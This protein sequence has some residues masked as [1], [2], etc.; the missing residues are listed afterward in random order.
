MRTLLLIIIAIVAY[1]CGG[2]NGAIISSRFIF[3]DDVRKHGSGN[4]GLTNFHRTY[5]TKGAAMVIAIDVLKSVIAVLVGGWLLG[6]VG[7]KSVGQIFAGFCLILGH[8]AP[9][10]YGFRGGKG[11]LC[12]GT[13]ILIVDPVAG[14][15]CWAV[16]ILVVIATRY[17]SLASMMACLLGPVFL[18]IFKHSGLEVLLT[19]LAAL[20]VVIKHAENIL[21]L[22]GGTESRLSF[23]KKE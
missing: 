3:H 18:A 13:M 10:L 23:G 12:A 7:E 9:V 22:I 19:L 1:F 11:V 8:I 16:F 21:R 4:A 5:G 6:T 17:V 15:C 14:L 2:L 20:L